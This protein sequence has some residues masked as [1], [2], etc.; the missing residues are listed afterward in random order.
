MG[1][2]RSNFKIIMVVL[3]TAAVTCLALSKYIQAGETA[4]VFKITGFAF[5]VATILQLVVY[6]IY[7]A[8]YKDKKQVK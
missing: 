5:L 1:N 7:P 3:L 2:A 6:G 4:G 8:L